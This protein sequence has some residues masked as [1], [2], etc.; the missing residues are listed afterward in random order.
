MPHT[1][2]HSNFPE[3]TYSSFQI[4]QLKP[5]PLRSLSRF[6]IPTFSHRQ[7][8]PISFLCT[9]HQ[10]PSLSCVILTYLHTHLLLL[11]VHPKD[12]G[13]PS[14]HTMIPQHSACALSRLQACPTMC[15]PKDCSLPGSSVYGIL[16]AKIL[17]WEKKKNTG[18]GCHALL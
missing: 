10:L 9:P 13:T 6:L 2:P 5:S 14:V 15:D 18:V 7:K 17:E 16:Q 12:R 1:Q 8:W 3:T 11:E 4:I